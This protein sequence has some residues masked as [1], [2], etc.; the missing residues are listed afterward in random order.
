MCYLS[1]WLCLICITGIALLPVQATLP[2]KELEA[3]RDLF[4]AAHGYPWNE[5]EDPCTFWKQ[6]HCEKHHVTQLDFHE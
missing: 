3:V 4:L 2:P 5:T 1:L 6:I